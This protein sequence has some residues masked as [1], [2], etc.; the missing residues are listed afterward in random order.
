MSKHFCCCIPVRFAVFVFSL[1]SLAG[2]GILALALWA[3]L[4]AIL[5][6]KTVND[7]D[8]GTASEGLKIGVGIAAGIYTLV[9][10]IS[11]L[12]FIGSIFR[13]RRLV[14]IFSATVWIIV[15]LSAIANAIFYYFVY[16]GKQFFNGCEIPDGNGGQKDCRIVLNTWQKIVYTIVSIVVLF[17]HLYIASVIGRYVDQ[18]ESERVYDDDYR[19]AKATNN[20]TYAPTYYPQPVQETHQGLLNPAPG[21]YPYTDQQH[22]FGNRV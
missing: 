9:A 8:F 10:V 18:L 19:L 6:G 15:I 4:V 1:L 16:S 3:V 7:V 14:K 12:G 2:S 22:S 21:A 13:S 5:Q 20:S 17:V 11:L